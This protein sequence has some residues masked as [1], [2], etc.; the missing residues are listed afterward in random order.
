MYLVSLVIGMYVYL[1]ST[2]TKR[3]ASRQ[4]RVPNLAE[5]FSFPFPVAQAQCSESTSQRGRARYSSM[6]PKPAQEKVRR[7]RE[8]GLTEA[9]IR[10]RLKEENYKNGRI[11]QLLKLTRVVETPQAGNGLGFTSIVAYVG[12]C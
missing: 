4:P 12:R 7:L 2:V 9:Q 8:E 1:R 3:L 6:A 11:S 10:A 5:M